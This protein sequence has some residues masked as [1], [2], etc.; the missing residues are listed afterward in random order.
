MSDSMKITESM[1]ITILNFTI[2]FYDYDFKFFDSIFHFIEIS[3]S[4]NVR[5]SYTYC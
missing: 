2:Q 5:R 4:D 1:K 3:D